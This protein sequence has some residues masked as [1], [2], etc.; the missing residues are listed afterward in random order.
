M[1]C[2]GSMVRLIRQF[3]LG[4][5]LSSK[6]GYELAFQP[7]WKQQ[8]GPRTCIA[9]WLGT[10]NRQ[11]HVLNSLARQGHWFHS[12]DAKSHRLCSLFKCHCKQGYWKGYSASC[13]LWL[14]SLIAQAGNCIQQWTGLQISFPAQSEQEDQFQGQEGSLWSGF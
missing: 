14:G 8:D 12:A 1:G 10:W 13:V 9:H 7:W 4:T 2:L 11:G 5:M 6:W 3:G